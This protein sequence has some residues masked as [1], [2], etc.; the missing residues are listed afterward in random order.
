MRLFVN[1]FVG[2]FEASLGASARSDAVSLRNIL[3]L[4]L[5]PS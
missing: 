5:V 1:V 4:A 3:I 2:M